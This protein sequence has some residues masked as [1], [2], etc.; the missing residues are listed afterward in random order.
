MKIEE[1]KSKILEV[2]ENSKS[3]GNRHYPRKHAKSKRQQIL[4]E[5]Q[6][7]CEGRD[8]ASMKTA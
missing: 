3:T 1:E 7:L 2:E 8:E 5:I 4:K 6:T